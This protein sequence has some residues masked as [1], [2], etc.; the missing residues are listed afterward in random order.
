MGL[1]TL[2]AASVS[3]LIRPARTN[4]PIVRPRLRLA[5]KCSALMAVMLVGLVCAGVS[6]A[7][8]PV[9]DIVASGSLAHHRLTNDLFH[10]GDLW[11]R[12]SPDTVFHRWLSQGIDHTVT[13]LLT[14]NPTRFADAKKTRI[15][16]GT[17][18]D[19]TAP[20]A[21]PV[22]HILFIEDERTHR[23]S[24]ITFE[25]TDRLIAS[26]FDD[27]DDAEVSIVIQLK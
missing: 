24:P 20:N 14:T 18:M 6:V 7:E 2:I 12:V 17:L 26:K 19:D 5:L 27:Y 23:A 16:T 15:L 25:T 21:T 3:Q 9:D 22:I 4:P 8:P 11:M 1:G 10:I 13:I